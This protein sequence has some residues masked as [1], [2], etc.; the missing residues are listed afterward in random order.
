MRDAMLVDRDQAEA[1]RR[2]RIA[3]YRIHARAKPRRPPGLFGQHQIAG[4]RLADVRNRQ[5][6]SFLLVDWTKPEILAFLMHDTKHQF[7][8]SQQLLHDMRNKAGA[9]LLGAREHT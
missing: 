5:L 1:A 2:E 6:A 9:A 3:Q 8:A 4:R 7:A